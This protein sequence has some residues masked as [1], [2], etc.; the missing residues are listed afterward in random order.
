MYYSVE[1]EEIDLTPTQ[2][3]CVALA[4]VVMIS[5]IIYYTL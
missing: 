4:Y 5:T 2:A 1:M 3:R